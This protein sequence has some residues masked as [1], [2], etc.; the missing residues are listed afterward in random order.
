MKS[1][2]SLIIIPRD[3]S[4]DE[5]KKLIIPGDY[6]KIESKIE[7]SNIEKSKIEKSY[8]NKKIGIFANGIEFQS[9]CAGM[10]FYNIS[11]ENP[12]NWN[13]IRRGLKKDGKITFDGIEFSLN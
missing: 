5:S 4:R 9:I 10:K 8:I 7:D 12:S 1:S 13:K 11:D 6:S 2:S 3:Y